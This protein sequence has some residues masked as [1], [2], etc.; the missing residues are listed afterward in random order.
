M[1]YWKCPSCGFEA[2]NEKAKQEHLTRMASDARHMKPASTGGQFSGSRPAG[3]GGQPAAPKAPTP[4]TGSQPA[5]PRNPA[6]SNPWSQ[7]G[8]KGPQ[9]P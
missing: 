6:P 7:P 1:A 5:A 9:K 8:G 4:G 3:M 2:Q